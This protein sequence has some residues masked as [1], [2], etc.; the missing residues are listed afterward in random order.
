V[1]AGNL[2]NTSVLPAVSLPNLRILRLTSSILGTEKLLAPLIG[3]KLVGL[4]VM[5]E[6][7]D[8]IYNS[9]INNDPGLKS[10][11]ER[12]MK[13]V[14]NF[15]D[16]LLSFNKTAHPLFA[17]IVDPCKVNVDEL[18]HTRLDL[19]SAPPWEIIN[20]TEPFCLFNGPYCSFATDTHPPV[21][22]VHLTEDLI[23]GAA[24]PFREEYMLEHIDLDALFVEGLVSQPYGEW[25]S[26]VM[27]EE[28]LTR[29]KERGVPVRLLRIGTQESKTALKVIKESAM[30]LK[31]T[32]VVQEIEWNHY[33][34]KIT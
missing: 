25:D 18:D 14:T 15:W 7:T 27:L 4:D 12:I 5:I 28:W 29:R 22:I 33:K 21:S 19:R 17:A 6:E 34:R 9:I 31:E 10:A 32:Q 23:D 16:K 30:E 24:L 2:L 1:W 8:T 13:Q 11:Y 26:V 20:I 3:P